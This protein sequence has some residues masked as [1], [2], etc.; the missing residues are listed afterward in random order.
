MCRYLW[1]TKIIPLDALLPHKC[2]SYL[3]TLAWASLSGEGDW[4]SK[5]QSQAGQWPMTYG[6][7][8][9]ISSRVFDWRDMGRTGRRVEAK[10]GN[11]IAQQSR[12]YSEARGIRDASDASAPSPICSLMIEGFNSFFLLRRGERV[13]T[14]LLRWLYCT[15]QILRFLQIEG[16]CPACL[17]PVCW[18]CFS[19]R[20]RW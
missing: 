17:K 11:I 20:L 13:H 18:R 4:P 10:A 6:W 19:N 9:Q 7:A 14:A 12:N 8:N 15:L 3:I 1:G 16:L 5:S 2:V